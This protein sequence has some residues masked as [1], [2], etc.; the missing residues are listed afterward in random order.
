MDS[1]AKKKSNIRT[2]AMKS[3]FMG[4]YL[5]FFISSAVQA[6]VLSL[7]KVM[8]I[9]YD[10]KQWFY[11]QPKAMETSHVSVFENQTLNTLHAFLHTDNYV[12]HAPVLKDLCKQLTDLPI[13]FNAKNIGKAERIKISGVEACKVTKSDSDREAVQYVF[14]SKKEL[15]F[16]RL[17]SAVQQTR[18]YTHYLYF[19]FPK[20]SAQAAE[21]LVSNLIQGIESKR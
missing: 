1:F 19:Y 21:P 7:G 11:Y 18:F 3:I 17:P 12:T 6:E 5:S 20:T 15:K 14:V 10:P 13:D 8:Q 4:L 16:G 2:L 9:S